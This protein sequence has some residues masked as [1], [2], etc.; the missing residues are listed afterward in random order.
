MPNPFLGALFVLLVVV[1]AGVIP[2]WLRTRSALRRNYEQ[3]VSYRWLDEP[4]LTPGEKSEA[5]RHEL[6]GLGYQEVGWMAEA[7]SPLFF[8]VSAHE[9]LPIYA[10]LGHASDSSGVFRVVPHL[11]SFLPGCGR[12]TTTGS[13]EFGRMTGA[14]VTEGPRLVQLRAWGPITP[15]SLDG[16][17]TGTVRAW[18]AGGRKFYPATHEALPQQLADDHRCLG[19]HLAR[20]GWLPLP[21]FLRAMAG[22][23]SNVLRF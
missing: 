17:H 14:A 8:H 23:A 15:T 22:K 7:D 16:Q 1:L 13:Q 21:A 10:L 11:E 19:E 12:L 20:A 3:P 5:L 18:L 6:E 2:T 9:E 4:P